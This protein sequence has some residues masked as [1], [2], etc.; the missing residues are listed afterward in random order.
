DFFMSYLALPVVLLFW[1]VGYLWKRQGWL[2]TSQIDVDTGR[3]EHNWEVI[4]A[5]RAKMAAL[6][7][8]RRIWDAVF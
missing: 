2:R 4:H 7:R 3:R 5:H 6:P 8:W 1:A